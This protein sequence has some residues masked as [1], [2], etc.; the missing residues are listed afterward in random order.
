[1]FR[2]TLT[3]AAPALLVAGFVLGANPAEAQKA[4]MIDLNTPEG[5]NLAGRRIQ[6]GA[7]DNTP[8]I[9]SFH[10]EAFARVPGEP[11]R[12][13]FDVEGY[14]VRQCVTVTDPVRGTGWRLVSRELLLYVDPKTGEMI[15]EWDNPWT[16][17]RVKVLQT[18]NDPVNQR[19]VFPRAADGTPAKWTGTISGDSW[20]NTLT[21]P[22]FYK[23]P[24]G[25]EYQLNVGGFY[26]ATEMFNFFG[27]VKDLTDP[28]I[29]NP[30]IQVGW[31]RLAEWLPWMEM[32]GRAG[33]IYMHA[34]GRKLDNYEQLPAVMKKAI[35]Q[36]PEYRNPPPGDDNRTNETS[37]TLF[38][39]KNP[40]KG[41]P[42]QGGSH[43]GGH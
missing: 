12:K 42:A 29:T 8:T 25:G 43:G 17:K 37:W 30:A 38:K 18:T 10:G 39:K 4:K 23:N 1:M 28:K 27:K 3:L 13:L 36:Y 7:V 31:V 9:Y 35:E 40:V 22:L 26:H 6:C 19:P 32:S 24:L 14:N 34:A 16:G 15:E 33:I 11:D 41:V 21:V 5:V 2:K 20:W